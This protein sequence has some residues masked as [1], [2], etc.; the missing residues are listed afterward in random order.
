VSV[1]FPGSERIELPDFLQSQLR[2]VPHG[3]LAL[4][5]VQG[6]WFITLDS[7][8]PNSGQA[9]ATLSEP[10]VLAVPQN[11][12]PM[13]EVEDLQWAD[14]EYDSLP[15]ER[16]R[17]VNVQIGARGGVIPTAHDLDEE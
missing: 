10:S 3:Q 5:F 11:A 14:L 9:N 17:K 2:D 12:I 13:V 15:L 16:A 1:S 7:V 8:P 4:E 6:R